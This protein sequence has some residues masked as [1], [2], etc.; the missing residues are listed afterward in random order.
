[1]IYAENL[2]E[3]PVKYPCREYGLPEAYE[4]ESERDAF[5]GLVLF[6]GSDYLP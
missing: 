5:E 6:Y 1:M 3:K 4:V 2:T